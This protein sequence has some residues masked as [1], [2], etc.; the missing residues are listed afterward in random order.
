MTKTESMGFFNAVMDG[1]VSDITLSSVLTALHMRGE[2]ADEVAG[3]TLGMLQHAKYF[4]R[5]AYKI[6]E[7]VGTGGDGYHTINISSA[8]AILGA[9]LGLKIC[10]HGNRKLT[11]KS[12]SADVLSQLGFALDSPAEH[13]RNLLDTLGICFL[14]APHYHPSIKNAMPVRQ[15]LKCRTIFNILG[16]LLNPGRPDYIVN[17]V[18]DESLLAL[19]ANAHI[20]LGIKRG[21]VVYG[22][23]LDEVTL[24]STT[25]CVEI[26]TDGTT[27]SYTVSPEDFGVPSI[28]ISDIVGGTPTENAEVIRNIANGTAPTPHVNIVCANVAMLLRAADVEQDLKQGVQM[29]KTAIMEGKMQNI[30]N[31]MTQI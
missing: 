19:V 4:P 22:S 6:G 14:M 13:A 30:L 17:G 24:H 21:V 18:F 28:D 26:F 15:T 7:I 29:A 25:D 31:T 11:S 10:K 9:S 20:E 2:T 5:P 3:A 1:S 27:K 8:S 16:P 12:G 23:G